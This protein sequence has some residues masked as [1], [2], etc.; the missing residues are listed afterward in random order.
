MNDKAFR[1]KE[2]IEKRLDRLWWKQQSVSGERRVEIGDSDGDNG[3]RGIPTA[4]GVSASLG[5]AYGISVQQRAQSLTSRSSFGSA[6]DLQRD[7]EQ[8]LGL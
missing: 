8:G 4:T 7:V 3:A 6:Q 5:W 2:V 1:L